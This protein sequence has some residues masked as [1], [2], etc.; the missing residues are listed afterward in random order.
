MGRQLHPE[1]LIP[2]EREIPG[3]STMAKVELV[4]A[5]RDR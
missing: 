2:A 5:L 4:E 1:R 3:R